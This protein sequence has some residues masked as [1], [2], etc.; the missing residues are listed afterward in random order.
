MTSATSDAKRRLNKLLLVR[1]PR[2][3]QKPRNGSA[4]S[5]N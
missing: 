2:R 4:R 1:I 5:A 3:G